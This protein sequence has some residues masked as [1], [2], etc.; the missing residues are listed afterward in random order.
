[1]SALLLAV[2]LAGCS[3]GAQDSSEARQTLTLGAIVD[4]ASF[5]PS[6]SDVGHFMQYLQPAYDTLIKIDSH[7]ELQ[8]MLATKWTYT[9]AA[10]TKLKL[11][12]RG[13]VKF[14]DGTAMDAEAVAKSLKRFKAANGPRSS[15]LQNV[16]SVTAPDKTTVDLTLASPD[17]ALVHNLGLVAGMITNPAAAATGLKSTPAGT[18]PYVLDT[19]KTSRGNA[20][21]FVRNQHYYNAAAFPFNEIDIRVMTDATA[22]LNAVKTGEADGAVALAS[23]ARTAKGSGLNV[24]SSPGDW[25]GLF[26]NDRNGKTVKAMSDVRVRQAISH[27]IDG[28][29]ILKSYAFGQGTSST[30]IFYPGTAAYDNSLNSR[31][32]YDPA[33]AKQ[34]LAEAGYAGG[35]TLTMPSMTAL[36]ASVYPIIQE[37][38]GAVG[39][40][41]VYKS[42]PASAGLTPYLSEEFPAYLFSW[43]SS[44]NW[45]D[46]NLL[47]A[48]NGAWN[49][50]HASDT[51]IESLMK[52][53]AAA[54]G[55]AQDALY[56]Q[57]S[58]YV[59]GQAW[60][61]PFYVADNIYMASTSVKVVA[62]PEQV[63]PSIYN[64]SPAS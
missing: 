37:E 55:P 64:Y 2:T 38:L 11:T 52:R 40:K 9:D 29:A 25:Q 54:S 22:R 23:Q 4:V 16:T 32:P 63:V 46:A 21:A 33:K 5:D 49:P 45:L 58:G 47:L 34:L 26:L 56:K 50:F 31:Y 10:R 18:G 6:Q 53:I 28:D 61:V 44:D 15:A 1:M 57:L 20:Y 19:K 59:V 42:Q 24:L 43:G 27:A 8:P 14:S 12:L 7:N 62:Q 17:P 51:T 3:S 39:I 36:F 13:D 41:V 30:Q 48:R 60:F 35:F